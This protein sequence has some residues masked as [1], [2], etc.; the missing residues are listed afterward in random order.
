MRLDLSSEKVGLEINQLYHPTGKFGTDLF[1]EVYSKDDLNKTKFVPILIKEWFYLVK[2]DGKLVIDYQPNSICDKQKLEQTMW[3]LWK[4]SYE[5]VSHDFI[6]NKRLRFICRKIID[7][8]FKGDSINKWTFGIITNG[9]RNDWVEQIIQSIRKQKIPLF[10]IIVCGA[11]F[12]RNE[13]D[14]YY[15]PFNQR[16]DKGWITKKKNLIVKNAQF[17]NICMLHDRMVLDKGWYRGMKKW[18]NCFENLGCQQLFEDVRVNDWIAS[19]YFINNKEN[20]QFSFESYVD[21]RDWYSTIWFSG[22]LK[23]FKKSMI[24]KNNLWWDETLYYGE[25]DTVFSFNLQQNGFIHRLN[26][27][28]Q[29]KTLTHKYLNPTF[30]EYNAYSL[31]PS[32]RLNGINAYLKLISFVI[33]KILNILHINLSYKTLENVRGKIYTLLLMLKPQRFLHNKEWRKVIK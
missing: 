3:W 1:D 28:S 6:K 29:A 11:Y 13:K 5:I 14:F 32:M 26:P 22:Q 19:H 20:K 23:I 16:D 8:K 17:E 15:I 30:I 10:E 33:L 2:K 9:K 24:V 18:G 7:T 27:F 25:E 4:G 12:D 31:Y 21:Y